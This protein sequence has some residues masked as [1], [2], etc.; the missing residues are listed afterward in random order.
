MKLKLVEKR[1]EAKGTRSFFWESEKPVKYL[2]GQY[3]YFTLPKLEFPDPRG[4]TRHFTLSSSPTEGALLR[5]TTRI[6][7]ESGFKKSLDSLEVGSLI[8][9]EGPNGT[10]VLDESEKGPH[11]L[12]AGGIGITPFRS[13]IKYSLDKN[14][15]SKI[16]LIYS[17][18]IP[19]EIVFRNELEGYNDLTPNLKLYLTVSQPQ[20]TKDGWN[21]LAGRIDEAMIP[22]IIPDYSSLNPTFWVC[23]PPPMVE[24]MEQILDRLNV[25]LGKLRSEK[26]T[27]Y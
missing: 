13:M 20:K 5:M 19:E 16:T 8:E 3:F 21:G 9:G 12:L 24:A 23:G 27:G 11:V 10:F 17:C 1:Q 22:K 18:S 14:L 15:P 6:R 25:P 4:A 7:E 26:F 2:P